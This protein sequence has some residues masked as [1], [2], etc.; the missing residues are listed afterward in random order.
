MEQFREDYLR[1]DLEMIVNP[2]IRAIFCQ[3]QNF[4]ACRGWVCINLAK[5]RRNQFMPNSKRYK[6][7]IRY[8]KF[9]F[10]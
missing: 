8:L 2:N 9:T 4:A 3:V 10:L 1:V 5:R 7:D 6:N